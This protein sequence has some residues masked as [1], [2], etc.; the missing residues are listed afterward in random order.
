[1]HQA[2]QSVLAFGM[3]DSMAK[4]DAE[5]PGAEDLF[6]RAAVSCGITSIWALVF[7]W[8]NEILSA[9]HFMLICS[10]RV[11][12]ILI[13]SMTYICC[14]MYS[15]RGLVSVLIDLALDQLIVQII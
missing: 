7:V 2:H 12:V 11:D 1:M 10:Y 5:T 4:I 6:S 9:N 14:E 3:F 13:I 8:Q 15:R